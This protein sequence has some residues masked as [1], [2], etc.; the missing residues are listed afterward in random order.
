MNGPWFLI[1][2]ERATDAELDAVQAIAKV[3][4]DEWWHEI[5]NVWIVRGHDAKYWVTLIKPVIPHGP[6][7][8]MVLKLPDGDAPSSRSYW[9]VQGRKRFDWLNK[10][11]SGW[12]GQIEA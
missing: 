10:V 1:V 5:E 12:R 6:S 7:G 3:H 11:Y 2:L 4:T 8:V 9:A